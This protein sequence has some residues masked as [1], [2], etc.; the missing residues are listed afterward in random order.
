MV[1]GA[2]PLNERAGFDRL[3]E[4]LNPHSSL[5]DDSDHR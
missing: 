5:P 1:A 3:R 4:P 2:V